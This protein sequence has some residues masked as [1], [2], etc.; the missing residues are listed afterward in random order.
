MRRRKAALLG[1]SGWIGQHFARLLA[2]HPFFDDPILC[3]GPRSAGKQLESVWILPEWGPPPS[4]AART[5]TSA[6]AAS[7]EKEGVEVVFS[8]LPTEEAGP[9]ETELARRGIAVFSNAGSHR[10]DRDVPLVIPE[11]NGAHLDLLRGR[12]SKGFIVTNSNCS[13]SGVAVAVKPLLPLL[14]PRE[15]VVTTYQSLSGAGFP[16]VASLSI[17]DN[18]L[19]YIPEEE[20]KIERETRKM[21]GSVQ[22]GSYVPMDIAVY[23]NCARVGTREGHLEAVTLDS[24]SEVS[25]EAVRAAWAGF[26]PLSEVREGTLPTAPESPVI[27][28]AEDNRP[29]PLLDRWAGTPARAKGMAVTVG[30]LRVRSKKVMFY[31]LVHNAVRG[32]AGGSVLNAEMALRKGFLGE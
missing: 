3:A 27:Y 32:G 17:T 12:K 6:T 10:M 24:K 25:V 9:I 30:R 26:R 22:D 5:I 13:T 19:P 29:Q 14:K 16:G 28:R 31:L 20:E 15:I 4:L 11:V 2:D 1:A 7:L 18:I 23:S 21:F 8:A